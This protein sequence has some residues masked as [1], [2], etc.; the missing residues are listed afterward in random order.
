MANQLLFK[1][2]QSI[3]LSEI[4]IKDESIYST[5]QSLTEYVVEFSPYNDISGDN[6]YSYTINDPDDIALVLV[7]LYIPINRFVNTTDATNTISTISDGAY[8]FK[9][10]SYLFTEPN[11][12]DVEEFIYTACFF[13]E[14]LNTYSRKHLEYDWTQRYK[15]NS[16]ELL[17]ISQELTWIDSLKLSSTNYN[18]ATEFIFILETIQKYFVLN[19]DN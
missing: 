4:F 18:R 16:S 19:Y 7:G 15:E 10:E 2:E 3:D 12:I 13:Q 17:S 1:I 5:E 8:S 6:V 14:V 9:V 11:T